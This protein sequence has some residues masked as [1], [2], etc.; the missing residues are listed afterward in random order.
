MIVHLKY[1]SR[2]KGPLNSSRGSSPQYLCTGATASP[3]GA[4]PHKV[5]RVQGRSRVCRLEVVVVVR[6]SFRH[7]RALGCVR[8][9]G[10]NG[11]TCEAGQRWVGAV[12]GRLVWRR[13]SA[14]DWRSRARPRRRPAGSW[15]A[16][17]IG[18]IGGPPEMA[19]ARRCDSLRQQPS[20]SLIPGRPSVMSRCAP[21][22]LEGEDGAR[23]STSRHECARRAEW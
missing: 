9:K 14:T 5:V 18:G 13:L 12:S 17:R 22:F 6:L 15:S 4:G 21:A 16:H 8:R 2:V 19:S 1:L 10:G 20:L 7:G 11:A 23:R 3:P